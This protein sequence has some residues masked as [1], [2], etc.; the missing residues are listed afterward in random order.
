MTTKMKG[1]SSWS[2]AFQGASH[3]VAGHELSQSLAKLSRLNGRTK[4]GWR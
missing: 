1:R 3:N 4:R 2:G